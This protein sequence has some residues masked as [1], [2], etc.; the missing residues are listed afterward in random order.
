MVSLL[1]KWL[2]GL[3]VGASCVSVI[4]KCPRVPN[5]LYRYLL[6]G[7]FYFLFEVMFYCITNSLTIFPLKVDV[8]VL[9]LWR[10]LC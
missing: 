7:V 10:Q 6:K 8:W 9:T 1:P 2:D 4:K 5:I 3:M